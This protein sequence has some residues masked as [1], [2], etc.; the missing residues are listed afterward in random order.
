MSLSQAERD[1]IKAYK[2]YQGKHLANMARLLDYYAPDFDPAAYTENDKIDA[3]QKYLVELR[4]YCKHL[5]KSAE[6]RQKHYEEFILPRGDED[7]EHKAWRKGFNAIAEDCKEKLEFWENVN[8]KVFDELVRKSPLPIDLIAKNVDYVPEKT[9]TAKRLRPPISSNAEKAKLRKE[10]KR[11]LLEKQKETSEM[12]KIATKQ[13]SNFNRLMENISVK[14]GKKASE[15][16]PIRDIHDICLEMGFDRLSEID[17]IELINPFT[18]FIVPVGS[19]DEFIDF[20]YVLYDG[21]VDLHIALCEHCGCKIGEYQYDTLVMCAQ[22]EYIVEFATSGTDHVCICE[23]KNGCSVGESL[24][25]KTEFLFSFYHWLGTFSKEIR[26]IIENVMSIMIID[27]RIEL[28]SLLSDK[29]MAQ[30]LGVFDDEDFINHYKEHEEMISDICQTVKEIA[31]SDMPIEEKNSETRKFVHQAKRLKIY[32]EQIRITYPSAVYEHK[33]FMM[34]TL[35]YEDKI[36]AGKVI[37][38]SITEMANIDYN[39]VRREISAP[40]MYPHDTIR[41][42]KIARMKY[43][44]KLKRE[45]EKVSRK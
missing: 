40:L 14:Y 32:L 9:V 45:I 2:T 6:L 15:R 30:F 44:K 42:Y 5:S 22:S 25:S 35:D 43:E 41:E 19:E 16:V 36:L 28:R 31:R 8:N 23:V 1:A 26:I 20:M 33:I 39:N 24:R 17:A 13:N 10:Y 7:K 37:A 11:Q 29:V 18:D 12:M 34:R 3:L 4:N 38:K 21:I 27:A